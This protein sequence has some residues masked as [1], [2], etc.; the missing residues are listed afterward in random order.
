[1]ANIFQS[2]HPLVQHKLT[3]LRDV[4]TEPKRFRELVREMTGCCFMKQLRS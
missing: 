2:T 4:K 1:M 3:L